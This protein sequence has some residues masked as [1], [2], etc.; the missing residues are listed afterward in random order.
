MVD[1]IRVATTWKEAAAYVASTALPSAG[2][3]IDAPR[4]NLL[5]QQVGDD[6]KGIVVENGQK[7]VVR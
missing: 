7:R 1:G 3:A 2:N 4:Y 5:G 6:Y